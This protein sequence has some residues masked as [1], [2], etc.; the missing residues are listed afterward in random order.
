MSEN[1]PKPK[2]KIGDKVVDIYSKDMNSKKIT[3][4]YLSDTDVHG[5]QIKTWFYSIDHL[6]FYYIVEEDLDF[7]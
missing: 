4:S 5:R 1:L 2:F 3:S 6:G 7:A